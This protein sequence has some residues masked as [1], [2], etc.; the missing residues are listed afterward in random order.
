MGNS[1]GADKAPAHT[2]VRDIL[3]QSEFLWWPYRSLTK[4]LLHTYHDS[5]TFR[6]INQA[7]ANELREI[8]RREQDF[9]LELSESILSK[10]SGGARLSEREK[11]FR[12]RLSTRFSKMQLLVFANSAP[13]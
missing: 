9:V 10:R 8:V 2:D 13:R 6:D 12:S 4:A 3:N 11:L 7:L 5:A 1:T